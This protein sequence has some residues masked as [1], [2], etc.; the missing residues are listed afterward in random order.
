MNLD[1]SPAI[2]MTTKVIKLVVYL[3]VIVSEV[4]KLDSS[5]R[6]IGSG[7]VMT[8]ARLVSVSRVWEKSGRVYH[9]EVIVSEVVQLVLTRQVLDRVRV[10]DDSDSTRKKIRYS[11]SSRVWEKSGYHLYTLPLLVDHTSPLD[12][13]HYYINLSILALAWQL[14]SVK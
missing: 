6:L 3:E 13:R 10:R 5:D 11:D 9:L 7:S 4:V 14:T 1:G 8:P 2:P 12:I